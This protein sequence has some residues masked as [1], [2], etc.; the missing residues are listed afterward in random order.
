MKSV[1]IPGD[2]VHDALTI[3]PLCETVNPVGGA[4][5]AAIGA[6]SMPAT[7]AVNRYPPRIKAI[8][9][10]RTSR[11]ANP[12][13]TGGSC[14]VRRWTT[15]RS[16]AGELDRY[17]RAGSAAPLREIGELGQAIDRQ[18]DHLHDVMQPWAGSRGY[19]N[20]AE[21]PCDVDAL[22][23]EDVCARL[24]DVKRR[25]DPADMIQANHTLAL[26]TA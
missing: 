6:S 9:P 14:Q 11:G 13:R 20:F 8:P 3:R 25:W 4:A 18:L 21:R 19:F 24:A 23:P 15:P 12:F 5:C 2:N 1:G 16:C 7:S 22:L 17:A 10:S 26:A